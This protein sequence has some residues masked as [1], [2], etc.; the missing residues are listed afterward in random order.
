MG[1]FTMC[2]PGTRRTAS[3]L[4]VT[5]GSMA[6]LEQS[7]QGSDPA[8]TEGGVRRRDFINIAAVSFAGVG[9]RRA[10]TSADQPR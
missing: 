8:E 10:R 7:A 1:E 9:G 6:T 2:L 5:R 3:I 4:G